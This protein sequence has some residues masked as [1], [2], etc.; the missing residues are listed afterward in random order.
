MRIALHWF[1]RDLRVTDN[2]ALSEAAR[3]ADVVIPVFILE[4]ALKTGPDVGA[5]RMAFLPRSLE[6][7]QRNL[8]A[9][10]YLLIIRR[11]RSEIELPKL[12]KQAKAEA[13]FSNRRYEPYAQ[14]RD[15]RVFN[16]LNGMGV[17]FEVFKDSV[18]WEE[19]DLLTQAGNPFTVFTPYARAWKS[20]KPLP[21]RPSLRAA[22]ATI[23]RLASDPL[24][25]DPAELGHPIAQP[26]PPAGERA[27]D[28]LLKAFL[29]QPVF[30]Y[31]EERDFPVLDGTS[32]LSAHLRC[33]NIG[34]RTVVARLAAARAKASPNGQNSCD[35]F[36]N[37]LIWREF[38]LQILANFPHVM[39]GS[40][41]RES[42]QIEWSVNREHFHAW[43]EG[44]T[45]YPIVDAAMRCL[46]ATGWMHNRLR[47]ITAMFLTKD[48]LIN[49]QWGERYFMRQLVDGDMAA[50]NG[51]W[52]WS[53]GTGTDAAPYFRIFNPVAQGQK[54]DPDG[55]FVR[56]WVPELNSLPNKNIHEPWKE[57]TAA[58]ATGYP[59]RL[60]LHEQQRK[61][62]L[63]M[64]STAKI[65]PK[66]S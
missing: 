8:A 19:L 42:A 50:N 14:T 7:L 58:T 5:A 40:F 13:V 33:G 17:G 49:W 43:C 54:F 35:V 34:I 31:A 45:G 32:H 38:H 46:N 66:G 21:P 6:S 27:A 55:T 9:L 23:P 53:A 51:G 36:L 61:K 22:H 60:V 65:A 56:V 16:A 47:M 15:S 3:H 26:L 24:P 30:S 12:C 20:K 48:L 62:F 4:D 41:R 1:R 25:S 39:D 37:E 18:M 28:E 2:T 11:G 64:F 52:Q 44:Q 29:C 63:A 57:P 59:E 10:G